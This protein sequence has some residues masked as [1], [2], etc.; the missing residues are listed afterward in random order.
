M[1]Q[2]ARVLGDKLVMVEFL[3]GSA[4]PNFF[5]AR[6]YEKSTHLNAHGN[7]I[8]HAGDYW[9]D[10]CYR[11]SGTEKTN[12]KDVYR[13]VD[14]HFPELLNRGLKSEGYVRLSLADIR[15]SGL[16]FDKSLLI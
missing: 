10:I 2:I 16:P 15:Q 7:H 14:A 6:A 4:A 12:H 5:T 3:Y 1:K 8:Q 13:Q 11:E 9:G